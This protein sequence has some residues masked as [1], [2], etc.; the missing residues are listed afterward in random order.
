[1]L[2]AFA[3][4]GS[5]GPLDYPAVSFNTTPP[6]PSP[7]ISAFAAKA[8]AGCAGGSGGGVAG[9]GG[10]QSFAN[11][12]GTAD[13]Q[14]A[15][16][17]AG[18]DLSHT[19]ASSRSLLGAGGSSGTAAPV[20][21]APALSGDLHGQL[22]LGA[23]QYQQAPVLV[24]SPT[25]STQAS[26]LA[27]AGGAYPSP[28]QHQGSLTLGAHQ[29]SGNLEQASAFAQLATAGSGLAAATPF[30]QH[31]QRG[32]VLP[33]PGDAAMHAGAAALQAARSF[34]SHLQDA[35]F[36]A[37]GDGP[38]SPQTSSAAAVAARNAL[39]AAAVNNLAARAASL[40][41]QLSGRAGS[42]ADEILNLLP[43]V[44]SAAANPAAAAAALEGLARQHSQ[45][46]SSQW[47]GCLSSH[48]S[49]W[50]MNETQT[51][52]QPTATSAAATVF[53]PSY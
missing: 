20:Q 35:M 30:A 48:S 42:A 32:T 12:P 46:G 3:S 13:R 50:L 4:T 28:L 6:A 23:Q 11:S 24:G 38:G 2:S 44:G 9:L 5:S 31:A 29:R 18:V 15:F 41:L 47:A 40:P 53:V 14:T 39:A 45:V 34:S 33:Y 26:A 36:Y 37:G 8:A 16:S 52:W 22:S 17:I 1:M 19:L 21:M 7:L 10:S 27:A 49:V 43:M 51:S 25:Q